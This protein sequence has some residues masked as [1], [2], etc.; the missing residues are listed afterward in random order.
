MS[1][2]TFTIK[3]SNSAEN[4]F[5]GCVSSVKL[6]AF[7]L[8]IRGKLIALSFSQSFKGREAILKRQKKVFA[9][10]LILW[11]THANVVFHIKLNFKFDITIFTT[12]Y[13]CTD[14]HFNLYCFD[15]FFSLEAHPRF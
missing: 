5:W 14:V 2:E 10:C 3:P 12:N 13:F 15:V 11:N 7:A 9:N 1:G 6:N 8:A 4:R